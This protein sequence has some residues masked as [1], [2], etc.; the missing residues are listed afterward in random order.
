[1]G[2]FLRFGSWIGGDRDGNPSVTPSVTV[3]A[4]ELMREHC[5]RFLE[6]RVELLAGRVSLS[7][8]VTGG[9]P[10]LAGLLAA[11]QERF[12]ELA[13]ELAERNGEEPYRRVFTFMRERVRA[14]R[15]GAEGAYASPDELLGELRTVEAALRAGGGGLT[16]GGDLHDVIRQV[17]VFGFHFARLDVREHARR[18]REALH[19]IFAT[20][21]VRPSYATPRRG[22]RCSLLC[23]EI[24]RRRPLV[25]TDIEGFA[26]A[27]R[28]C[29]ARSGCSARPR[30]R[31]P[32]RGAVLHRLGD[33]GPGRPA[34]GAA[35]VQGGES[36]RG[37]RGAR[38]AAHR[39][40]VRGRR[41]ARRRRR[42]DGRPARRAG[43]P[44]PPCARSA[45]SR[46]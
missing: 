44:Q 22:E 46:R 27:T 7:E 8:R 39:A 19:D 11:G 13:R 10:G 9:A 42:H 38:A 6:G 18:H 4:L 33:R 36:H 14:T 23:A 25:P 17:E 2:A 32:R 45:T 1:M 16:A 15:A 28:R 35:A 40:P 21:G 30:R 12:P 24:A 3:H 26:P 5:L 31:A 29:C 41:D 43:L 20:L 34:R 37:R